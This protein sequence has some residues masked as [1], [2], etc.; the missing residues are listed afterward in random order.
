MKRL[1]L[2]ILLT[3]LLLS[4]N[5]FK[6]KGEYNPEGVWSYEYEHITEDKLKEPARIIVKLEKNIFS[7][8]KEKITSGDTGYNCFGT[9]YTGLLRHSQN[10]KPYCN[11]DLQNEYI[12]LENRWELKQSDLEEC[13]YSIK[14]YYNPEGEGKTKFSFWKDEYDFSSEEYILKPILYSFKYNYRK[15]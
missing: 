6:E 1:L 11:I 5:I 12:Y 3:T 14:L 10:K 15:M 7:I 8:Y 13:T 4:C 9:K 2:F